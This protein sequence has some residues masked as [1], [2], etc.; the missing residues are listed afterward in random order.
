MSKYLDIF[1]GRE[2]MN[3]T[4]GTNRDP[5]RLQTVGE[6]SEVDPTEGNRP[7]SN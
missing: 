6:K 7:G 5:N 2:H 4:G 1:A 3:R